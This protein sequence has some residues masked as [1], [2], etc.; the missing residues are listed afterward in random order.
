M[1][2][3]TP[4]LTDELSRAIAARL[5]PRCLNHNRKGGRPRADD[6]ACPRGIVFVPREGVRWQRLPAAELGCPSGSTCRRYFRDWTA[7]GVWAKAHVQLLD[8]LGEEGW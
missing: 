7:A 1:P 8:L 3:I 2:D 6:L 4:E 5:P